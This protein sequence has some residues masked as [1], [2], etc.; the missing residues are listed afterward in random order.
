MKQLPF[1]LRLAAGIAVTTAERVRELPKQLT[2][3]PVT[4]ASQVMQT[5]MR[6][7]QHV[8][9]LAIRG[10]DALS[11]LRTA[12]EA[13]S[14]ATFDEDLPSPTSGARSPF[15]S[16]YGDG[17]PSAATAG[18]RGN[19]GTRT[20]GD[21]PDELDA[22]VDE[23][24][25]AAEE[26]ALADEHHDGE[27]DSPAAPSTAPAG[28]TDY[29]ELTLPQI[30]ARLRRFSLPELEE[31]LDY[32]KTHANRS[33]FTGMLTRRIG[34]VRQSAT[35]PPGATTDAADNGDGGP[36]TDST[37]SS[38]TPGAATIAVTDTTNTGHG[39]AGERTDPAGQ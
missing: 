10:D 36:G 31:L 17:A 29:D 35:A 12:E 3:L 24:P 34:N 25:W 39:E 28:L 22:E 26:H 8:T 15:D 23:D 30:R 1:P 33:S 27:F 18:A 19:G 9:E 21:R 6:V 38:N 16:E 7:Q 13:P 5:S 2:E 11:S 4:V 37:D 32:E 14:W 20:N